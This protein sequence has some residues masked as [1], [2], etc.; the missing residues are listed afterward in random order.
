LKS[1]KRN[2]TLRHSQGAAEL[3][4]IQP[5]DYSAVLCKF[6]AYL[7]VKNESIIDVSTTR[8]YGEADN[9]KYQSGFHFIYHKFERVLNNNTW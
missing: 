5:I 3:K 1:F 2:E 6:S 9:N 4:F 8:K 7:S